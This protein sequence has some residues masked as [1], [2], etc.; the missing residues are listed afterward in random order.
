ME[1]VKGFA[2]I[3]GG[4]AGQ[5][6]DKRAH[7]EPVGT[8]H[9]LDA[10]EDDVGP[11]FGAEGVALALHELPEQADGAGFEADEHHGVAA[12]RVGGIGV[13]VHAEVDGEVEIVE[14]GGVDDDRGHGAVGQH[15]VTDAR[16]GRD[17]FEQA[18]KGGRVRGEAFTLFVQEEVF[19][20]E[21][22]GVGALGAR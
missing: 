14:E 1:Q 12:I 4:F 3:G 18:A 11:L 16:H 10:L 5:A 17:G 22:D 19:G 7:G 20:G 13:L 6:E 15:D 8:V 9:G 21:R 2:G